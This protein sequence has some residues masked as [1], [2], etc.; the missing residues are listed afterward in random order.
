MLHR[1][2]QRNYAIGILILLALTAAAIVGLNYVT[3]PVWIAVF[4]ILIPVF[5]I[6]MAGVLV[7]LPAKIV[8]SKALLTFIFLLLLGFGIMVYA[9]LV[10]SSSNPVVKILLPFN[11]S[12]ASF[13][14]SRG[15]YSMPEGSSPYTDPG[16]FALYNVFHALT[17]FY[18]AWLG[19][20][21]FGRKLLNRAAVSLIPRRHKNLIWGYSEGAFELA[22]DMMRSSDK[23]DDPIFIIDN[24]IEFESEKEKRIFDTLSNEG[25]IVINTNFDNLSERKEDF[26]G[27]PLSLHRL[28]RIF[29]GGKYFGGYRH[30]FITEN[31]D[32]NVKYA[33]LTL[34]QLGLR[35]D[36]LKGKTHIFVRSE[37]EGID[38]FF[39]AKLN[40]V[41]GLADK[42][43]M[44]IFNQS[45]HT[46]RQ[47]VEKHPLLDLAGR[48]VPGSDR[49][50]LTINNEA[51]TVD[52]EINIL[53][54][55]LGWTGFEMLKKEVC[56][57]Q[58]RG[59]CK[60]NIVVVDSDYANCHGRYQYIV[61]EAARFGVNICINPLVWLDDRHCI[62]RQW[63][64]SAK[65][66]RRQDS[67]EK[68]VSHANGHL[69]Y[70]WLGF[71][72]P[73]T[74]MPNILHFNRIIVALG[75]DELNVNTA[76]QLSKFRDSYLGARENRHPELM[77]EPI[78]AHVRDR[79][80]Y[81]YYENFPYAPIQVFGGLKSI[82]S[83]GNLI[84]ERMD[85]IAKLV[86][87]VYAKYTEPKIEEAKLLSALADGE[88]ESEWSGCSI[89]DQDSSRAV[90]MNIH[91]IVTIAGGLDHLAER[92]E[93]PVSLERLAELEHRRWNA[94][95]FMRGIGAWPIEDIEGVKINGKT[96]HNGKLIIHGALA[97]HICLMDYDDLDAATQRVVSLGENEDFKASDRRIIRHFPT[98]SRIKH[99]VVREE[100]TE[101][102]DTENG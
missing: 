65:C 45:D 64:S 75:S 5:C 96:R 4:Q 59:D 69:F 24:D 73:G 17:Y 53:L 29:T 102:K 6:L 91:N 14:P 71:T 3:S 42:V 99:P 56:D 37:Q 55:G 2:R 13:F 46:A 23:E 36:R 47:F 82:Y 22:K 67:E 95:H 21:L 8:R 27:N 86:N 38:T 92:L 11:S 51:L 30:Y 15:D 19:F 1:S 72:D 79:E 20:S 97:R 76:L 9:P 77:P 39:Q 87:H 80:R 94:F 49:K 90:A 48:T 28:A 12:L 18:A 7:S 98:F 84:D 68:R 63:L 62:H 52:G 10:A 74:G 81:S 88:A 60:V 43:E 44:H 93:D 58:F 16:L 26:T 54:L 40:E 31:Q 78:F 33:F 32:F 57:A 66:Q 50:W 100:K 61:R 70:E 83:T 25:I 41:P 85:R 34:T 101:N 89:F 35:K